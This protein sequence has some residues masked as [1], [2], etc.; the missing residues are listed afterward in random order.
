MSP[1]KLRASKKYRLRELRDNDFE[2]FG[3]NAKK[4]FYLYQNIPE[5]EAS[6]YLHILLL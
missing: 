4:R 6:L 5:L 3:E 1:D 2:M